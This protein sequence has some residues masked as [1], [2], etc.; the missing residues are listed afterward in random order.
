MLAR[1]EGGGGG[2]RAR[3]ELLREKPYM[4]D[5]HAC[6]VQSRVF[7]AKI[8]VSLQIMTT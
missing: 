7:Q 3:H 2:A 4:Y 8:V 6:A 1:G 5:R